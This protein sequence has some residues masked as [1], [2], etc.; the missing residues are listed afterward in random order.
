MHFNF[1]QPYAFK[2]NIFHA[3]GDS[4]DLS[5]LW[6]IPEEENHWMCWKHTVPIDELHESFLVY[7]LQR[8]VYMDRLRNLEKCPRPWE[9]QQTMTQMIWRYKETKEDNFD[10]E[11]LYK[12][13]R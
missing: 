10:T 8:F 3:L 5:P 11:K 4:E 7:V 1:Q 12:E 2:Y 6:K 9:L 13:K